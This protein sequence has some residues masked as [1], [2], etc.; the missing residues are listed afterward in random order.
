L[1]QI[2]LDGHT[3]CGYTVPFRDLAQEWRH[4]GISGGVVFS[5]VEEIYNRYDPRFTDSEEY[6]RSRG[7]VHDYL[8]GLARREKVFPYFFVWNDFVP[9]PEGFVGIKWHRHPDEPVYDYHSRG[10]DR[11]VDEICSRQLPIVLEEEFTHTLDF[12]KRIKERT[13]V[14]IPHMG[15]LNGGYHRLKGAGVFES[16]AVWVDTALA[17][18]YEIEDFAGTYGTE[19]IIF[20]SDYPFGVPALENHKVTGLFSADDLSAVIAGNLR[21]LLK[22][23][24][25]P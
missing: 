2:T 10:C 21:R 20:G 17:G 14:I 1:N 3:H 11:I 5:P 15:G 22:I 16:P 8:L 6:R 7:Q 24:E 23:S 9:I 18:P 25:M 13:V 19:R 4:G 12:I